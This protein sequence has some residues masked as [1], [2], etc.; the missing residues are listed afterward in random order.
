VGHHREKRGGGCLTW[1]TG[2]KRIGSPRNHQSNSRRSNAHSS[3]LVTGGHGF[4]G[5]ALVKA[6]ART[7][8]RVRTFDNDSRGRR[9]RLGDVAAD[10]EVLDGDIRDAQAVSHAARGVDCVCHLA[11]V[12]GTESFYSQPDLVLDVAVKGIANVIDACLKNEVPSL[13]LASS[14]EVYQTAPSI[15]T[16]ETVPLS[17]PDP[18][19]PRYSYGGGKI[20]SELMAINFGRKYFEHVTIFRPHNVYGPDMGTG[21]VIPQL[22]LRLDELSRTSEG[23]IRLPIRG[24]GQERRA[25][26]YIDDLIQGVLRVIEKGD[27]LGIYHIGSQDEVTIENLAKLM[28]R[29]FGREVQV[30]PGKAHAGG[31]LRRCPDIA[32]IRGLGYEPRF[33]LQDGLAETLRWYCGLNNLNKKTA[34]SAK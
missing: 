32:K 25:F 5:S 34:E 17:V 8:A 3:F 26:V 14:S 1:R 33:S 12:N 16:D 2:E 31:T 7:G 13:T 20:L 4:I 15:P 22:A 24:T 27:H 28:G 6:L 19:N 21:H 10:V 9:S 18:L 23:L 29:H 30:V 11:Y